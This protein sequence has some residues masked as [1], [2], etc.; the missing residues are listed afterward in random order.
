M[1]LQTYFDNM[2]ARHI[3][4]MS[5]GGSECRQ[6]HPTFPT[7]LQMNWV[8]AK[9]SEAAF[10]HRC[11]IPSCNSISLNVIVRCRF[12]EVIVTEYETAWVMLACFIAAWQG[13]CGDGCCNNATAPQ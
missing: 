10:D 12:L 9:T 8:I 1:V 13:Q 7:L 5:A 3:V 11:Y 2:L 4:D 6:R